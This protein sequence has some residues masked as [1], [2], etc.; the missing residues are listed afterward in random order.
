MK[1]AGNDEYR[2]VRFLGDEPVWETSTIVCDPCTGKHCAEHTAK[3]ELCP[4]CGSKIKIKW[5]GI[6]CSNSNCDWWFCY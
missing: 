6:E 4:E 2:R 5:S 3:E 1:F